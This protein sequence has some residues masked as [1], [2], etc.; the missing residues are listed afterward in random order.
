MGL[1]EK[2][3][4]HLHQTWLD[5]GPVAAQVTEACASVLSILT[6]MGTEFGIANV[7]DVVPELFGQQRGPAQKGQRVDITL[8][9]PEHHLCA[10]VP[11]HYR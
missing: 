6:D 9:F 1:A 8:F 3:Q 4:A 11:S 5:Y 2:T 7:Q 10:R